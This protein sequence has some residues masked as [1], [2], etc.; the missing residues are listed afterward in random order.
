MVNITLP[1]GTKKQFDTPPTGLDVAEGIS[2]GLARS[3][4]AAE[5]DGQLQD[6]YLPIQGDA[7]LRL[8]THPG[9]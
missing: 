7:N 4:V 2:Q 9:R 8:I 1:D 3:C 6:L 5:V